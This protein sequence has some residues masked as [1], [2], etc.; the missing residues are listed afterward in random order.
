MQAFPKKNTLVAIFSKARNR[1]LS[2]R[3]VLEDEYRHLREEREDIEKL[4][5]AYE[6][7][8]KPRALVD[9]DDLLAHLLRLLTVDARVAERLSKQYE[10]VLID[11]YQ[12]TNLLQAGILLP[13]YD[14]GAVN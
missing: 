10:Y 13:R 3:E 11:E 2:I 9:F 12:D 14:P 5:K 7:Y 8:K 4:F 6:E 1:A